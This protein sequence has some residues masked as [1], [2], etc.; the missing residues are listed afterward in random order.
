MLV[1]DAVEFTTEQP[2]SLNYSTKDMQSFVSPF[3]TLMPPNHLPSEN[4]S[5]KDPWNFGVR[6]ARFFVNGFRS[7]EGEGAPTCSGDTIIWYLR[8]GGPFGV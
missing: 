8:L 5:S 2:N 1:G 4:V 7:G 6:R 3:R